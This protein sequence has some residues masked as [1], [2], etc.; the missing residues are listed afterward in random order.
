V[1][2]CVCVC[3]CVKYWSLNSI[4]GL[5]LLVIHYLSFGLSLFAF[6]LFFR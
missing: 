6:S 3:V 1:C 2:V 5:C 4:Q